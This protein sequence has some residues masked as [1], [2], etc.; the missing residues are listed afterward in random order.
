VFSAQEVDG[1]FRNWHKC[2]KSVNV[3]LLNS[4]FE[5][6]INVQTAPSIAIHCKLIIIVN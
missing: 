1:L 3:K 6:V 2:F 5:S 4:L